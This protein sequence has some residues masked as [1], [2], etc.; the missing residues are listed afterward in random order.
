MKY[1]NNIGEV[2]RMN[3]VLLVVDYQNDFVTG[4]LGFPKAGTLY[5]GIYEKVKKCAGE[6]Y[7]IIFTQDT[8]TENYLNTQ[9][10]KLLPVPHCV[11]GTEGWELYGELSNMPDSILKVC[12]FLHKNTFGS[13][14]LL[15]T[16]Q[17]L[18]ANHLGSIETVELC[19]VVTNMCV[20][21]NAVI[22]K[23]ALPEAEI[24]IHRD[25]CASFDEDL[26]EKAIDVMASM[27]MTIVGE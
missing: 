24:I 26:H 4:A 13:D 11:K 21:S 9:E 5:E 12:T 7:K 22:C 20:V 25:L 14:Q 1:K 8:H 27:Q 18:Q 10:G 16:L 6:G 3:K 15:A 19:G 2:S 17:E 23:S